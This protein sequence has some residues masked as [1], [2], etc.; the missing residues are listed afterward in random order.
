[1]LDGSDLPKLYPDQ[2]SIDQNAS[3]KKKKIKAYRK[4]KE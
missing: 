4:I 3:K 1:M 2:G